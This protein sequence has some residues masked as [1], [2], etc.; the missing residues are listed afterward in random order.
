MNGFKYA[1]ALA[2]LGMGLSNTIAAAPYSVYIVDPPITNQV[3]FPDEPLPAACKAE[4]VIKM[5]A[6]RGER[7]P[8]S[9]VVDTGNAKVAN[10][11]VTV[12]E[13]A[14]DAASLPADIVDVRVAQMTYRSVGVDSITMPWMLVHDPNMIRITD[15]HPQ[16]V[17]DMQDKTV[18]PAGAERSLA[19]YRAGVSKTMQLTRD[20]IDTDELQPAD[21]TGR[22]QFWITVQVP[23]DA[24]P[25]TYRA[26]VKITADGAPESELTLELTVPP[27]DLL[28]PKFEYSVYHPTWIQRADMSPP[29]IE[30]YK[31]VSEEQFLL[32]LQNMVAHGCFNPGIYQGPTRKEDGSLDFSTFETI[33]NLREQAG[34]PKGAPLYVQT[35]AGEPVQRKLTSAE[36]KQAVRETRELV[37]WCRER[38]YPDVFIMMGDELSGERLASQRDSI[39]AIHDGGA[40]VWAACYT[41]FYGIL[42]DVF[43]R[44]IFHHPGN[45]IVDSQQQWQI[46]SRDQILKQNEL[47]TYSPTLL[48]TPEIQQII[49]G[50]H[51]KGYKIYIYMD[52]PG[53]Y[54]LPDW[55]RRNRGLGLWKM[56]M[57]GTMTWAYTHIGTP[58]PSFDDPGTRQNGLSITSSG[59]VIRGTKG[60]L[61]TL[62]WEAY[63]EGYDD[64][65]YLATLQQAMVDA[66]AAG[67]H[68]QLIAQTRKWLDGITVETDLAAWRLEM[69]ER[70]E[71][72]LKR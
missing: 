13:L 17:K 19:K 63:R 28:P 62:S 16:W 54:P 34:M 10:V 46:P 42:G 35:H 43:D 65:R 61:D 50:V 64:A 56:G 71:A 24:A 7:E 6:C 40:K 32:E 70:I 26:P 45:A 15:G 29:F 33:L 14:G 3:V 31:P 53:G 1:A 21:V 49:K 23:A 2:G 72:L 57:D 20:L 18:G 66:R 22:Q 41:D 30:K 4:T 44:P 36:Y 48:M 67:K 60:V 27:F 37:A 25:G 11:M 39:K 58:S 47:V 51:A 59:F 8:A 5:M 69:A 38:G 52:P 12:G 68:A 9:F 55:H